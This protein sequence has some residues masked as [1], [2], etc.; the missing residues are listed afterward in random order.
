MYLDLKGPDQYP[1]D[2]IFSWLVMLAVVPVPVPSLSRYLR[3]WGPNRLHSADIDKEP[4]LCHG[5]LLLNQMEE[6]RDLWKKYF[7]GRL[8]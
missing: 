5:H 8:G 6:T 2:V 3:H 1:G 4:F 7:L